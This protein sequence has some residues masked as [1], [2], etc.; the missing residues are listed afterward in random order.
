MKTIANFIE[1]LL[2]LEEKLSSKPIHGSLKLSD[3]PISK[4][5]I[6]KKFSE[7]G[8]SYSSKGESLRFIDRLLEKNW[9]NKNWLNREQEFTTIL[10][11]KGDKFM[12]LTLKGMVK[13]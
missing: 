10:N 13:V 12:F 5:K 9:L 6:K 7:L 4:L 3:T 11:L 8:F 2:K 1:T